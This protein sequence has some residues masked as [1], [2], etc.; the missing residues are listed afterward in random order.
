MLRNRLL[1]L[2]FFI[3]SKFCQFHCLLS[4]IFIIA[5]LFL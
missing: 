3:F 4:V 2:H 5:I 1:Y